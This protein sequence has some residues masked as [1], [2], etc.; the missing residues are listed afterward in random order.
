MTRYYFDVQRGDKVI[1]DREGLELSTIDVAEQ[2]AV[3]A[4]A[5]MAR[6]AIRR[7]SN[8]LMAIEVR[9][10]SGPLVRVK[11]CWTVDW[12]KHS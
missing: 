3:G 4:A 2:E 8:G 9:D 10:G 11:F 1:T 6:D 7:S 12:H 5:I